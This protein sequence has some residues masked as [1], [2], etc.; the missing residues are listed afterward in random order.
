[1]SLLTKR[2]PVVQLLLFLLLF[3]VG[4]QAPGG[5]SRSGTNIFP[6]DQVVV[7]WSDW[8]KDGAAVS[9]KLEP[10]TYRLELTANSDGVTAEWVGGGCPKTQPM[11]EITMTCD[12]SRAG[13]LVI[14]NPTT[15]G[16]G[17]A[18][19]TTVKVTKLAR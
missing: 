18:V 14:T 5:G 8:L 9:W 11:R 4:C 7:E 13:Q 12:M 2:Q 19:S 16:L 1:M 17:A 6:V 3:F 15:F 10:G